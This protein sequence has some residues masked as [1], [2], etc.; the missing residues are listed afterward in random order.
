[1]RRDLHPSVERGRSTGEP[2]AGPYGAFRLPGPLGMTLVVVASDGRDWQEAGLEGPPWEHVS[3]SLRRRC[4]T[5]QEMEYVR[6]LFWLPEE[7]VLQ[8]SV[9]RAKHIN[10]H[11]HCLHLW[12]PLGME[13]PLPPPSTVAP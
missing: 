11:P 2:G 12:R 8:F 13:I 5:W 10:A 9:P 1:M 3:V 6:D 4:P 7:L